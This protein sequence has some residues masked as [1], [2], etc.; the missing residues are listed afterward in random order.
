MFLVLFFF[1]PVLLANF[2]KQKNKKPLAFLE[3]GD[4]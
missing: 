2:K 1:F 3:I 4:T